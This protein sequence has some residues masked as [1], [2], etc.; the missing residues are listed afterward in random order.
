MNILLCWHTS[1]LKVT[2]GDFCKLQS[3]GNVTSTTTLLPFTQQKGPRTEA[4]GGDGSEVCPVP[5]L[6]ASL[7]L[8]PA[9]SNSRLYRIKELS[10]PLCGKHLVSRNRLQKSIFTWLSKM[11]WKSQRF[12]MS[13]LRL[14][15]KP[16]WILRF[17]SWFYSPP[18]SI[19]SPLLP[20]PVSKISWIFPFLASC[21]VS[22][23]ILPL[24]YE[25]THAHIA[26]MRVRTMW[27]VL[28]KL[29]MLAWICI[30]LTE[31]QSINPFGFCL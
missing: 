30:T 31:D 13:V 18:L 7:S 17:L 8:P 16:I 2:N 24:E 9:S 4:L 15:N 22:L 19:L 1:T 12:W 26:P 10:L 6:Y 11:R 14:L 5:A 3:L 28:L 23:G 29:L 27:K 21:Y 20:L 25:D